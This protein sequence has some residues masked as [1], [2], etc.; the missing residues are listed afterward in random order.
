MTVLRRSTGEINERRRDML[1]DLTEGELSKITK[2]MFY[3][4][5]CMQR[6]GKK[7]DAEVA[8]VDKLLQYRD[9]SLEIP[10]F[11]AESSFTV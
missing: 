10:H 1:V 2:I 11:I 5:V 3:H 9:H 8:L 6:G 7:A 4:S